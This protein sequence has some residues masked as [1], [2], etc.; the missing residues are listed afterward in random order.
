[1]FGAEISATS[2]NFTQEAPVGSIRR[3]AWC[4]WGVTSDSKQIAK[5]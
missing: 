2:L 1:M 4:N 5:S 3:R